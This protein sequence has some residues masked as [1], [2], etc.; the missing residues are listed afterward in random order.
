[1]QP[2]VDDLTDRWPDYELAGIESVFRCSAVGS[3]ETIQRSL[4]SIIEQTQA[5]ELIISAPIFDHQAR[6]HSLTLT[7]QVRDALA[8][9]QEEPA[10][11]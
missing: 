6:K 3:P 8:L 1:M 10:V 4:A 7:A 2:P 5:D 9:Q 11:L